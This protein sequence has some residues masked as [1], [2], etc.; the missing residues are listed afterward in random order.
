MHNYIAE[1]IVFVLKVKSVI[2]ILPIHMIHHPF[3]HFSVVQI[4]LIYSLYN[5]A[6]NIEKSIVK[7]LLINL[8]ICVNFVM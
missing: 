8:V 4:R 6:E 2:I 3:I 1:G 5:I 7:K